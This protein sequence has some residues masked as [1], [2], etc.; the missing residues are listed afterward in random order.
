[1]RTTKTGTFLFYISGYIPLFI[2]NILVDYN[3]YAFLV[4]TI[5]SVL[6]LYMLSRLFSGF[7][8]PVSHSIKLKKASVL[9]P[10]LSLLYYFIPYLTIGVST[11]LPLI[12]CLIII[13]GMLAVRNETVFLH[14]VLLA[15]GC[16]FYVCDF[17]EGNRLKRKTFVSNR[18]L[19][20]GNS[21]RYRLMTD[22][23]GIVS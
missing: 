5:L 4:L 7:Q 6:S 17:V 9:K 13:S 18:K 3:L 1:M 21:L 11:N 8:N 20:K 2:Y 12:A 23:I 22:N 10:N 19:N 16:K 15:L 14:P